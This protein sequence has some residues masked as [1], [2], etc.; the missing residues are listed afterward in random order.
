MNLDTD[1]DLEF[2]FSLE[3]GPNDGS[4]HESC[5]NCDGVICAMPCNGVWV[6]AWMEVNC[7][8]CVEMDNLWN[9]GIDVK[10]KACGIYLG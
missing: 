10:C 9:E 4:I 7:K 1:T 3:T 5:W 6:P 2:I 8:I